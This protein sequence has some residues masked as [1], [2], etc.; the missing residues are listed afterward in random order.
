MR[1]QN[2]FY[3][4]TF[5]LLGMSL[6]LLALLCNQGCRESSNEQSASSAKKRALVGKPAKYKPK[7]VRPKSNLPPPSDEVVIKVIDPGKKPLKKVRYKFRSSSRDTAQVTIS[8]KISVNA[9]GRQLPERASPPVSFE[10]TASVKSAPKSGASKLKLVFGRPSIPNASP[11]APST[12]VANMLSALDGVPGIQTVTNKGAVE[13]TDIEIPD[14]VDP[15]VRKLWQ[16]AQRIAQN[17]IRFPEEPIGVGARWEVTQ[18][19]ELATSAR[20]TTKYELVALGRRGGTVQAEINQVGRPGLVPEMSNKNIE[21]YLDAFKATGKARLEFKFNSGVSIGGV[22]T[23]T[24][25]TY[26]SESDTEDNTTEYH[27]V[28]TVEIKTAT[29]GKGKE[30]K[31]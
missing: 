8:E 1:T 27:T 13:S 21:N 25:A 7:P 31:K 5:Y 16:G 11:N 24:D 15:A 28:Q 23:T 2:I 19:V 17:L 10:L 6:I 4:S 14:G 26:T 22:T 29:S 12:I 9:N 20:Q 3:Y 18:D 30:G